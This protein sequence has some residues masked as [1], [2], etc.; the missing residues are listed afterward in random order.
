MQHC[1]S[2]T[3]TF[4]NLYYVLRELSNPLWNI[5]LDPTG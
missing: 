3:Q 4:T 5:C 2:T 1:T